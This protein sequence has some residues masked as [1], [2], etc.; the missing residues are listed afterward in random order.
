MKK[1]KQQGHLL[2]RGTDTRTHRKRERQND[3]EANTGH[4]NSANGRETI[5]ETTT[6]GEPIEKLM[7]K[8][9]GQ[10]IRKPVGI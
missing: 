2:Y 3:R 7:G 1:G 8:S 4:S 10:L 5:R 6:V 9:M